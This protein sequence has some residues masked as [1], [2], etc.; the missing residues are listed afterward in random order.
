M[1]GWFSYFLM[2]TS[3]TSKLPSPLIFSSFCSVL[4]DFVDFQFSCS[5]DTSRLKILEK[6]SQMTVLG[7]VIC[8]FRSKSLLI[9]IRIGCDL[10]LYR[11]FF[12]CDF[13]GLIWV[14]KWHCNP[15]V[16]FI[17][18]QTF[19]F[20]CYLLR[21][22]KTYSTRDRKKEMNNEVLVVTS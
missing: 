6:C 9:F 1:Y 5:H 2:I 4:M 14:I 13:L 10:L 12:S 15:S 3:L 16:V 21:P 18:M 11:H 19:I 17:P 7:L 22:L 20:V 8:H